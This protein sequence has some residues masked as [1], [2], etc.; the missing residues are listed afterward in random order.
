MSDFTAI[1]GVS[2][3][4]KE[5]LR[6]AITLSSDPQLNGVPIDL[7]S[8]KELSGVSVTTVSL[9]LYRVTRDADLLNRPPFR[10]S[11]NQQLTQPLPVHL[12]YLLTPI[13]MQPEDE[14]VLLGRILQTFND[15]TVAQGADLQDTLAGSS[16]HLRIALETLTV[17]ELTRIWQA[18][19]EPYRTS[20]TYEVQVVNIDSD[21]EPQRTAPVQVREATY[22]EI[23]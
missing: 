16:E 13:S 23:V 3:T 19:S 6:Q 1:R 20:V 10:P 14:H 21:L 2:L 8:P 11:P 12:Y 22:A 15:H 7:R 5:L 18:L 9:W 4:L 17:E